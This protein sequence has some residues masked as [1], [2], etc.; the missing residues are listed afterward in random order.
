M[1]EDL[2]KY[3]VKLEASLRGVHIEVFKADGDAAVENFEKALAATD[4]FE[5]AAKQAARK[6]E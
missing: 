2:Q 1:P 4:V 6:D 3:G 5:K